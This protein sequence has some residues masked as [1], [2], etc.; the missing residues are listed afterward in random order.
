MKLK[1]P[2]YGQDP[3]KFTIQLVRTKVRQV[4]TSNH[5]KLLGKLYSK[6]LDEKEYNEL[7]V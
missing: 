3:R 6:W 2:I 7:R 4:S 5:S 1:K